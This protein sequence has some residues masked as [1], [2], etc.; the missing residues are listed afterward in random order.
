MAPAADMDERLI[1]LQV[2]VAQARIKHEDLVIRANLM[3]KTK[4]YASAQALRLRADRAF[5]ELSNAKFELQRHRG[6]KGE[7]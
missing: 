6:R 4:H 2:A 3:E 1:F 5:N 7:Q